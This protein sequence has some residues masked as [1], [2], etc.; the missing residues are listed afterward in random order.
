[1]WAFGTRL[2]SELHWGP[3]RM[4]PRGRRYPWSRAPLSFM[5]LTHALRCFSLDLY[6]TSG[7]SAQLRV[8]DC[9][10][11]QVLV[12]PLETFVR[13]RPPLRSSGTLAVLC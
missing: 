6:D 9:V 5:H 2:H 4:G 12:V 10:S 3:A 1:M 11:V 7:H 13:F 8:Q